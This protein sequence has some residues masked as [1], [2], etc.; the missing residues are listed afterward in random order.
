MSISRLLLRAAT[1]TALSKVGSDTAAP[2][3]AGSNVFDSRLD[4]IEFT[5]DISEI[6]IITVYT[7]IDEVTVLDAAL[8]ANGQASRVV[9]LIIEFAVATFEKVGDGIDISVTQTDAELEAMLDFF[10]HQI[11]QTLY[12]V[13]RP[14]SIRWQTMV[15][16]IS[17]I[18]SRVERSGEA[19]N[20]LAA[21]QLRLS[22]KIANDCLQRFEIAEPGPAPSPDPSPPPLRFPEAPYLNGLLDDLATREAFRPLL[23]TLRAIAGGPAT[24]RF[25][26]LTGIGVQADLF[27]H[28]AGA[29]DGTPEVVAD[30]PST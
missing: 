18:E 27:D 9:D 25:P 10:E 2:T 21:R 26:R 3:I 30:W 20:R 22:C 8:G 1:V 29:P 13:Q 19:N 7:D 17:K 12:N 6:P 16:A 28:A 15:R 4:P 23:D 14:A 24:V 5:E 11:L